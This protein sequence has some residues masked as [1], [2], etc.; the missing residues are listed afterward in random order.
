M[1]ETDNKVKFKFGA[2]LCY[3]LSV[4]F[5]WVCYLVYAYLPSSDEFTNSIEY[6]GKE[7]AYAFGIS[8]AAGI[9]SVVFFVLMALV[10]RKYFYELTLS[11]GKIGKFEIK[12]ATAEWICLISSVLVLAVITVSTVLSYLYF[13]ECLNM[14]GGEPFLAPTDNT[15]FKTY[16]YAIFGNTITHTAL[17]VLTVVKMAG[18]HW[19]DGIAGFIGKLFKSNKK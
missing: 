10:F 8:F 12:E 19:L 15:I 1:A 13:N 7:T 2:F 5:S 3:I 16:E 4:I 6:S 18:I 14:P 9:L 11:D 17:F